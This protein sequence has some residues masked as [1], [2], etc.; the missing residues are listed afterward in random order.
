MSTYYDS[1]KKRWI[2]DFNKV[3]KGRRVR[4]TKTLPDG[5]NRAKAEAY[6]KVETDRLYLIASG[7]AEERVLIATAVALYIKHRCPTLKNGDGVIKELARIYWAYD[8]RFMDELADVAREYKKNAVRETKGKSGKA[9][10]E[11]LSD[12]SIKNKLSYLRA[13]C[14]Y[15]QK[16][17]GLVKNMVLDVPVPS[18]KNERQSYATRKE[19]LQIA[20]KCKNRSARA[21][22]R[23]GFYSGMRLGEMMGLEQDGS[24]SK[25]DGR[26]FYLHNTKNGEPRHVPISSKVRVTLKYFP[27]E[28]KKRW[29]QRQFENAR[30]AA[31]FPDLHLHDLRHSAASAMI[32]NGVDL[33]TVGGILGHIDKRSTQRYSHLNIGTL[34]AAIAKIK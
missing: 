4:A 23:V 24:K 29:I 10:L 30:D 6:A 17:H 19:M 1:V 27:I 25:I 2:F 26:T 12:A 13:A 21:I 22:I 34:A 3:V 9:A 16:E 33:Y 18:V 7:A 28:Y 5:W 14:R 31:G 20:R 11:P 15:A 8:G 32:N